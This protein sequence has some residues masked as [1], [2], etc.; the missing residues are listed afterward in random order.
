[1]ALNNISQD[2]VTKIQKTGLYAEIDEAIEKAIDKHKKEMVDK[3]EFENLEAQLV[4]RSKKVFSRKARG[5]HLCYEKTRPG[6]CLYKLQDDCAVYNILNDKNVWFKPE[7][8][9]LI[10]LGFRTQIPHGYIGEIVLAKSFSEHHSFLLQGN[11]ID[12]NCFHDVKVVMINLMDETQSF[13]TS[14]IVFQLV[15]LKAYRRSPRCV[16]ILE[17]AHATEYV[18]LFILDYCLYF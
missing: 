13:R 11:I 18:Y 1:M 4:Q 17:S 15:L 5:K 10:S 2:D 9:K 6:V 12:T 8:R 3:S 7:E 16:E 14:E